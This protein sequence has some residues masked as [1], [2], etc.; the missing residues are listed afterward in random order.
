MDTREDTFRLIEQI[1]VQLD[2][3]LPEEEYRN[4]WTEESRIVY[5]KYFRKLRDILAGAPGPTIQSL[6]NP[7]ISRSMDH[8]GIVNGKLLDAAAMV[9]NAIRYH[10]AEWFPQGK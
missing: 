3:P 4:G 5:L 7:C 6:S 1:I 10:Y 8:W 2:Q 9:S